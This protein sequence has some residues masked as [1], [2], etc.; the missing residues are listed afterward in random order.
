[1]GN[2]SEGVLDGSLIMTLWSVLPFIYYR[3]VVHCTP[4]YIPNYIPPSD[5]IT[6][7]IAWSQECE[8]PL[9]KHALWGVWDYIPYYV[10]NNHLRIKPDWLANGQI[11]EDFPS[12]IFICTDFSIATFVKGYI[13]IEPH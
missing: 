12:Y 6:H 8:D 1:M 3:C 7:P 4:R 2:L 9:L 10:P 13:P 11:L 5:H